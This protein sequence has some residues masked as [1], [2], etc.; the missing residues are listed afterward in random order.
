MTAVAPQSTP[1]SLEEFL[2]LP[3]TKPAS[4]FING[5]VYQKPMLQG[6]HSR[7][8]TRSSAEIN[9]KLE[10]NRLGYA[11]TELRCTFGNRSIVPDIAAFEWGRIPF[12]SQGEIEN[13]FTI[14]PDWTIEI[15]G[16]LGF[17]MIL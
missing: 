17:D 9:Q 8:Q 10:P 11:F 14:Y 15:L 4:E 13:S 12:N 3:E 5:R 16:S 6:K 1:S 7:I 2:Q